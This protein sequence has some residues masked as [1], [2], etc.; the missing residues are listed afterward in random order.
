MDRAHPKLIKIKQQS[1]KL[2]VISICFDCAI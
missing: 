2:N 1:K